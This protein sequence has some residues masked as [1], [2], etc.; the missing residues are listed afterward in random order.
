MLKTDLPHWAIRVRHNDF[1]YSEAA[2]RSDKQALNIMQSD[3][4]SFFQYQATRL[5]YFWHITRNKLRRFTSLEAI[6]TSRPRGVTNN[7]SRFHSR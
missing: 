1:I 3:D 4:V 6:L 5:S 7:K 2:Y